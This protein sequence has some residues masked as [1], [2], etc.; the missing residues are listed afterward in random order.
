MN[1]IDQLN[2]QLPTFSQT[3]RKIAQT[4]LKAPTQVVD[5]TIANLAQQAQVSQASISRFCKTLGLAGFHQLKIQ[6]AQLTAPTTPT[7]PA[8]DLA[9]ALAGITAN[10]VAEV[11]QTLTNVAPATLKIILKTLR[12]ASVIQVAAA[13]GTQPVAADA[14]YKFNQLGKLALTDPTW[15]TA[16]G[17]TLNL[18]VDAVLL[19]ISNSGETRDLLTQIQ[20]AH[21]RHLPVIAITNRADSHIALAAD[22]HIQTAVRQQVFASEY[23][24][25]RVAATAMIEALFLLLL[26]QDDSALAHIKAHENWLAAT[27]L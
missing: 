19:V 16:M 1:L 6:L 18:P 14:G 3:D 9:Q 12:Q 5:L 22:Q 21:Q 26:T 2:S 10:K 17:Q 23:Y 11:Q 25:S 24:F 15:D 4:I 7:V 8:D 27:K 20:A 13:G